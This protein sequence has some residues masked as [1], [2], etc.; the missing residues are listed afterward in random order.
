MSSSERGL[1][2]GVCVCVGG[3][4]VAAGLRRKKKKHDL[5]WSAREGTDVRDGTRVA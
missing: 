5:S 4:G 2:G 3:R 1:R